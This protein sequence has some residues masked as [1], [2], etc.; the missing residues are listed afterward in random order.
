MKITFCSIT[1]SKHEVVTEEDL[2]I[3]DAKLALA[4]IIE[5]PYSSIRLIYKSDFLESDQKISSLKLINSDF[6][7]YMI[8]FNAA[9]PK[10]ETFPL[11]YNKAFIKAQKSLKKPS[12]RAKAKYS[13]YASSRAANNHLLQEPSDFEEKVS[14]LVSLGFPREKCIE[15]LHEAQFNVELA[16]EMLFNPNQRRSPRIR[17]VDGNDL[18]MIIGDI[19]QVHRQ[20]RQARQQ[21]PTNGEDEAEVRRA[22]ALQEQSIEDSIACLLLAA[23]R[24]GTNYESSDPEDEE[25]FDADDD[26]SD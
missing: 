22:R 8:A 4:N 14:N 13:K 18:A 19:I 20:I 6:I 17:I 15:T 23:S 25:S 26:A 9:I 16:A 1:G 5:K 7:M 10:A 24:R 21:L 11:S 2:T 3:Y 12:P